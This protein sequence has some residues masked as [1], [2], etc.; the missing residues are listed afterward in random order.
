MS[1]LFGLPIQVH[2]SLCIIHHVNNVIFFL[3]I[4][5]TSTY[6][7]SFKV[8]AMSLIKTQ[9]KANI[10]PLH[11]TVQNNSSVFYFLKHF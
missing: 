1:S 11:E 10:G 5:S 3:S 4:L 9:F 2:K 8:V 6:C 7:T